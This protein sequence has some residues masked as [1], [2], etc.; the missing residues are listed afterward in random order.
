MRRAMILILSLV[1]L[2]LALSGCQQAEQPSDS[3]TDV[4]KPMA[5][6]NFEECAAA[7]NPIMES[8]PRQCRH[9]DQLFVEEIDTPIMNPEDQEYAEDPSIPLEEPG[10]VD[11]LYCED[12]C[13]DGEC[14]E[15]VCM[16]I[17]CPCAETPESCPEDCA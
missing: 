17:G 15:M 5:V 16:G 8:Y 14:Q 7:G 1:I 10:Y 13:G 3:G 6:T 11:E 12:L 4:Q 2:I 9:G